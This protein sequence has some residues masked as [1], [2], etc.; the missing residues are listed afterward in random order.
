MAEGD[1]AP[2]PAPAKP[3]P[4]TRDRIK[5][6]KPKTDQDTGEPAEYVSHVRRSR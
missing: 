5:F 4:S 6:A 3:E 2:K 1:E